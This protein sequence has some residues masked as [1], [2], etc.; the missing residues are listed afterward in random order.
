MQKMIR[1]AWCD[2]CGK[3]IQWVIPVALS[4]VIM[5]DKTY[6]LCDDCYSIYI[7]AVKRFEEDFTSGFIYG[8]NECEE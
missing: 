5:L 3:P 6:E 7:D 4:D 1:K 2:R 8:G